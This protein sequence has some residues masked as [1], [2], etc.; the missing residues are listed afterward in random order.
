MRHCSI[1]TDNGTL[2]D[3]LIRNELVDYTGRDKQ[4]LTTSRRGQEFFRRS[5]LSAYDY[6]CCISGLSV[7]K[8][9]V[10]SHIIPWKDDEKN[11]LN[12]RNGLCL[13]SLH[14]KAFDKGII[15]ITENMRVSVS[16]LRASKADPFFDSAILA[17]DGK[18]ILL[19]EKFPPNKEFLSYHRQNIFESR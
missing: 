11:R 10:A 13:S 2:P 3:N 4:V 18:P 16:Q 12:P 7:P 14:D 8:L 1:S 6:K 17:Y 19:P 5:V 15:A 9:L